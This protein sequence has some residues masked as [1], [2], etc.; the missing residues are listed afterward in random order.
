M[1][2]DYLDRDDLLGLGLDEADVDRLLCDTPHS[3]HGGRPV[4][5]AGRLHDVLDLL[6]REGG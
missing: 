4:I 1:N 6:D 2:S 3:G 5:E